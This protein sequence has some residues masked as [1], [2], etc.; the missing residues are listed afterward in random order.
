MGYA[1]VV[2]ID[3]ENQN[4]RGVNA[5]SPTRLPAHL[6]RLVGICQTLHEC[7]RMIE[8]ARDSSVGPAVRLVHKSPSNQRGRR[9]S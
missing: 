3:T 5:T 7:S 9:R 8:K 4:Q 2:W 1:F 6:P